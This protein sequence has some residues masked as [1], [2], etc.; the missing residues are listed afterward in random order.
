MVLPCGFIYA[1]SAS[2]WQE[3]AREPSKNAWQLF[4]MHV[5]AVHSVT[6]RCC[7]RQAAS[8]SEQRAR[9]SAFLFFTLA[10]M[11]GASAISSSSSSS[12]SSSS[13]SSSSSSAAAAAA[14]AL[15][16]GAGFS[17][18]VHRRPT[19]ISM[20]R[21]HQEHA[22]RTHAPHPHPPA[23]ASDIS[24]HPCRHP[25]AQRGHR[26]APHHRPRRCCP[27]RPPRRQQQR[28][29]WQPRQASRPEPAAH[30]SLP[31]CLLAMHLAQVLQPRPPSHTQR[32]LY[33]NSIDGHRT[34]RAASTAA[35]K[36]N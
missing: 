25:A 7:R 12:L 15:P 24:S 28:S 34:A 21:V 23:S 29:P 17:S 27:H 20:R 31:R 5:T 14:A 16:R 22:G 6:A 26:R 19:S 1:G 35:C 4:W 33:K 13:S 9:T 32:A 18:C 11:V 36:P 8:A 10:A 2:C 30:V 3:T